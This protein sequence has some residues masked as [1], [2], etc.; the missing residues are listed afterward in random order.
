MTAE[1]LRYALIFGGFLVLGF[2]LAV[3]WHA[4]QIVR[5]VGAWRLFIVGKSI[6]TMFLI[7]VL[8]D[9]LHNPE[10]GWRIPV[11]AFAISLTLVSLALLD[12]SYRRRN[13]HGPLPPTRKDA[14]R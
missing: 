9:N 14:P 3:I 11:A 2:N 8:Y 5:A 7:A 12:H 13:G 10:I 6:F 4:D 1:T